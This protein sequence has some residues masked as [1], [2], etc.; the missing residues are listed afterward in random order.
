MPPLIPSDP[1]DLHADSRK[2][3]KAHGNETS[4]KD[5]PN[6][7]LLEV[8]KNRFTSICEEMGVTLNRTAFSP[9][10]K[11][12]RDF[13]CALFDANG[14]MIAQAAHIPVHLGS[15]P[16]SV[17]AAI[18]AVE[19]E[20]G[21]MVMLNDPYKG[22]THLPDITI[23]A[24]VFDPESLSPAKP[25]AGKK[26]PRQN[27]PRFFVAN[28]A[29]H[30]DVGGMSA[31]SMPLSSSLFQEGVIIPPLKIVKKGQLDK[32]LMTLFLNNVR[33]PQEREGDFS[34]QIMANLTG[35]RR[36][37]E[38]VKKYSLPEVKRYATS[39]M[40]YSE[41]ITRKK[42]ASIPD[43]VYEFEDRL[44]DD[45]KGT[46]DIHIH[47]ILTIK[48]DGAT[49]DFRHSHAQVTGSVNAV[50]SITLS[51]VIYV[52]RTLIKE[53]IPFNAGCFKPISL[54]TKKG[55]IVDAVFP[56]AVAGGNVETSQRVVDT[57]LGALEKALP[58]QIPAAGQGTMNNLTVG[59]MDLRTHTPFAYYETLG[60]GMGATA[61]NNGENAVHSHMTNT[62]NTP[63]EALEYSYPFLVTQYAIRKHSGGGGKFCGGDGMIREMRMLGPAEMTVLSERRIHPPHGIDGG[64]PGACGNNYIIR[65]GRKKIMPG[66]FHAQLKKGDTL[67]IETP[68][69]GGYGRP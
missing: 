62:L 55:T 45:G 7:I 36:I 38:L 21:D 28:R 20:Q 59:G 67:G 63:V 13:S 65:N 24:P 2:T 18:D 31:G 49:L 27:R 8:F 43:G 22:G 35:I 29:H 12:R 44:D 53:D 15:M 46:K 3:N 58:G 68:G 11:E 5:I 9:N 54:I 16:L 14:A 4:G 25:G 57:V 64:K 56:A 66:K 61:T 47:V 41:T 50:F 1:L 26:I 19:F 32:D 40:D 60:G 34:A 48:G 33:T 6:P 51:A 69:G 42:I 17:K 52:F 30:A 39:L 10:I 23:V 37:R